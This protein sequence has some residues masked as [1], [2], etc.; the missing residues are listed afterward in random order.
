MRLSF[1]AIAALLL[2]ACSP[3]P[4]PQ[5]S[6]TIQD[7][8]G[9]AGQAA[10]QAVTSLEFPG[11]LVLTTPFH[12]R[13]DKNVESKRGAVRRRVAL[14]LLQVPPDEAEAV[15]SADLERAGYAR[16]R[17]K[18][19]RDGSHT[20]TFRKAKAKTISVRFYP[21]L[22]K[23]PAHADAKSMVAMSWQ[24]KK[25]PKGDKANAG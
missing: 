22:A 15:V 2:V 25:A 19:E 14:E 17:R 18:D 3:E 8:A 5:D 16:S 9:V 4:A 12:V 24:I 7:E 6:A 21:R 20:V 1:V 10:G 13:S 11:N 23:R